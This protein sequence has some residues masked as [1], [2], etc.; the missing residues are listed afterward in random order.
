MPEYLAALTLRRA[1]F[2]IFSKSAPSTLPDYNEGTDFTYFFF[3]DAMRWE[4]GIAPS[5]LA[6]N[7]NAK[8]DFPPEDYPGYHRDDASVCL[9]YPFPKVK[10]ITEHWS[11][12]ATRTIVETRKTS[13]KVAG[14]LY[15]LGWF[16]PHDDIELG[17][18]KFKA[19]RLPDPLDLLEHV[20]LEWY[21]HAFEQ[22][23]LAVRVMNMDE[24]EDVVAENILAREGFLDET[25]EQHCLKLVKEAGD[26]FN[27]FQFGDQKWNGAPCRI[28]VWRLD[29]QNV[30]MAV[31]PKQEIRPTIV[32]E[33][34]RMP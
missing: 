31:R 1:P 26:S 16:A 18:T 24:L 34:I 22:L 33:A 3:N 2:V 6:P 23:P 12:P 5:F 28:W 11:T 20:P 9:D 17:L 25:T 27:T 15:M 29:K 21:E 13:I 30:A 14:Q 10:V 8:S 7:R 32:E 19:S 4:S